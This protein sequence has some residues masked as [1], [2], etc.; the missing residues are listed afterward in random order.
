[1]A[2]MTQISTYPCTDGN[3]E[4]LEKDE[5][6]QTKQPHSYCKSSL[7]PFQSY[8]GYSYIHTANYHSRLATLSMHKQCALCNQHHNKIINNS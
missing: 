7:T 4:F 3:K 5:S 8:L 6:K 1:M 2:Q